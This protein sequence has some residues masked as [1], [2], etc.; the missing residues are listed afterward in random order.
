MKIA[1]TGSTGL[2]GT[3]LAASLAADGHEVIRLVRR[4]PR[5]ADEVRWDPRAADAGIP[6]DLS[7]TPLRGLDACVHLAGAG[8]ADHRWTPSYKAELRASRILA[9]QTLSTALARLD[10]RPATL[11]AGSAIGW[12]G[13]TGGETATEDT[14]SGDGFLARL[15]RDWEAAAAPAANAGIRVAHARSGVVL[16]AR[17]GMLA[18]L[19]LPARLGVLPRFGSG[20]Q[21]LS[22]ISLTDEIRALRFL[23][24]TPE[25]SGPYNLTAPNPAT[26]DEVT[27]ALH[28]AF[29]R[30]DLAWARVPAPLLRLGLGEMSSELLNNARVLPTRLRDAGFE[31]SHLTLE[32]ALAAELPHLRQTPDSVKARF[33]PA[34]VCRTPIRQNLG[35]CGG[36]GG[37]GGRGARPGGARPGAGAASST[38]AW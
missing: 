33:D 30:P 20:T 26:N 9:T 13:D 6:D 3:A 18:K 14:P 10:P 38:A 36:R 25:T 5:R 29:G 1:L 16:S 8:V 2:I 31:F 4:P 19:A 15:V 24:D 34:R 35:G 21:V 23:L 7:A 11:I 27:R 28:T 12:Y 17:G 32:A 22:W 37:R